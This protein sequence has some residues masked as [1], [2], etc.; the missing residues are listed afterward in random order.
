M[1]ED[2]LTAPIAPL[3]SD[4]RLAGYELIRQVGGFLRSVVA[5][6]SPSCECAA[7]SGCHIRT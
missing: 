7:A 2:D 4:A 1:G 6:D 3:A 5:V